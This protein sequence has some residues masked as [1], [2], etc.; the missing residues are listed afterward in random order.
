MINW[1]GSS[2]LVSALD[3]ALKHSASRPARTPPPH[4]S[5]PHSPSL[6]SPVEDGN[7]VEDD[8]VHVG[9]AAAHLILRGWLLPADL[10]GPPGTLKPGG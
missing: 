10:V 1:D 9:H 8:A 2:T 4:P 6:L 5:P 3:P 7:H